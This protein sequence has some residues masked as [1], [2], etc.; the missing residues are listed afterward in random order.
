M[1][2]P[3]TR[4]G[5]VPSRML[6]LVLGLWGLFG[7]LAP[8]HGGPD[9]E[10]GVAVRLEGASAVTGVLLEGEPVT[11]GMTLTGSF[12]SSDHLIAVVEGRW[13]TRRL[14]S[15]V[16]QETSRTL[17]ASLTVELPPTRTEARSN[18]PVRFDISVA[19]LQGMALQPILT[20]AFYLT[21]NQ[22][23]PAIT[24]PSPPVRAAA[25]DVVAA[26]LQLPPQFQPA[27]GVPLPDGEIGE[28]ELTPL[29]GALPA[30]PYWE[31]LN[32]TI[33]RRWEGQKVRTQDRAG[34]RK[35]VVSFLLLKTGEAQLVQVERSSGSA[36]FDDEALQAVAGAHPFPPLPAAVTDAPVT[37]H[38]V[39]RE[40]GGRSTNMTPLP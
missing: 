34:G 15:F 8:V 31:E 5:L 26:T 17:T 16:R 7:A 30:R 20:R 11:L 25:Q 32:Q 35:T 12:R 36:A 4:P 29:P 24:E 28:E 23:T 9:P 33:Q 39:F 6:G 27:A 10:E 21:L 22:P 2:T 1:R 40:G 3:V 14:L 13:V 37:V 18:H 38:V 19:R